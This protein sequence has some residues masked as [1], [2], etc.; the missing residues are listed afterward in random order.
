[1]D[2]CPA[3]ALKAIRWAAQMAEC[4]GGEM[5]IVHA[6]PSLEG[7]T[8]EY[9]DPNWRKYFTDIAHGE[10]GRMQAKLGTSAEVIYQS[11]DPAQV[12]CNEAALYQAD[13]LVIGR[14]SAAGVFGRLRANACSII[15]Q[16]PCPVASV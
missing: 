15:R 10:I 8:S 4:L 7:R 13:L 3:Q 6:Y 12:V 9:F 16:S 5:A 14:G 11:G 1:M 2:L